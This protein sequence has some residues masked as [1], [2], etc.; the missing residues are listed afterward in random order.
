MKKVINYVLT[1]AM[2][3]GL[4]FAVTSCK[5]DDNNNGGGS[6]NP[7]AEEQAADNANTFWSVAANLVSPFDVTANY[8][9]KTFEPTIG[10]AEDGNNTVRVVVVPDADAAAAH[11]AAIV[12]A[13]V[14]EAT[15]TYTYQSDAVGTLAYAKSTDGKS[16]AKVDVSIK[17]I[18]HLQQIVYKTQEQLGTNA[19]TDGVPYYWFGDVISRTRAD[20]VKEYWMCI[21]APFTKQGRTEAVWATVSPLPAGNVWTYTGSNGFTYKVP[22]NIGYDR[23]QMKNLAEM[24]FAI[25]SPDKWAENMENGDPGMKAFNLVTKANV[26]FINKNFW[27]LV[28]RGWTTNQLAEKIFGTSLESLSGQL[29][30][31]GLKLLYKGYS[32]WTLSSNNLSLYQ[33]SLTVGAG[34]EANARHLTQKE[35]KKSVIRPLIAVNCVDSLTKSPLM[36]ELGT[37]FNKTDFFGDDD[38]RYIFR[39]ATSKELLGKNITAYESLSDGRNGFADVYVYSKMQSLSVGLSKS[40]ENTIAKDVD[41]K[42]ISEE[43]AKVGKIIA[44]DGTFCN[45]IQ[46][47]ED[48][49]QGAR[50]IVA[51]VGGDL[52]VE[53]NMDYNGLAIALEGNNSDRW[54]PNGA[55][56]GVP[57]YPNVTDA[58]NAYDG[59]SITNTLAEEINH[60]HQA[61]LT[62]KGYGSMQSSVF[63]TWFIP[64]LGQW[65]LA[66]QGLGGSFTEYTITITE[67]D[68][69]KVG[70]TN[71]WEN[72]KEGAYTASVFNDAEVYRFIP[73][74]SLTDNHGSKGLASPCYPF[75]AFKYGNG[76]TRNQDDN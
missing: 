42:G 11:F 43:D 16:L 54:G 53:A 31:D 70:L 51:Y 71:M 23:E 55:C 37:R 34:N 73:N 7:S 32:W 5:D 52:R 25:N 62:A 3:C 38:A 9:N 74:R 18:P 63:S 24:L 75:I 19:V 67:Q 61:A 21:Q 30:G 33:A 15:A 76:A 4:S 36:G 68:L 41:V 59:I 1:A 49:H 46:D 29:N 26:Q 6:G 47:A 72:L 65:K 56:P 13:D 27:T 10:E 17:Q 60:L 64:S 8:Q 69:Q 58:L 35:V 50:A 44:K 2:V 22:T 14:K 39:F 45:T 28:Q 48:N 20:G 40:M 57:M 12:N 66:M